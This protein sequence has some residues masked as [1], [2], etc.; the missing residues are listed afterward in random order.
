[1]LDTRASGISSAREQQ[2]QA[3]RNEY[4]KVGL[5][6]EKAKGS[7]KFGKGT[8]T[9]EQVVWVPTVVGTIKF[10]VVKANTPFLLCLQDIN[11]LRIKYD[12]LQGALIKV[13]KDRTETTFPTVMKYG[14]PFLLLE[15]QSAYTAE[16][17]LSCY[18]TESELKRLHRRFGYLLV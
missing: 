6:T 15:K 8:A 3:L 5:T 11:K 16:Q 17:L 18:I 4:P 2:L 13:A 14:H 7:I 9:I 10:H 1:M 12:N